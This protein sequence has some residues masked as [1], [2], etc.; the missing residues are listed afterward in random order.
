[1]KK[2]IAN[3]KAYQTFAAWISGERLPH[4]IL[5][6][7]PPGCGKSTFARQLAM[8]ALCEAPAAQKP[9]GICRHCVKMEK[10]IHPDFALYEGEGRTRSFHIETVR[11]LR[12]RAFIYPNE[13]KRKVFLLRNIQDMSVQAQNALLKI[14]EEPPDTMVFLC[15]CENKSALLE[16]ILSRVTTLA[17]QIPTPAQCA[18]LLPTL[19]PGHEEARYH[20]AAL[21]AAGNVGRALVL[22]QSDSTGRSG[23][24]KALWE[25]LSS[26]R[27]LDALAILAAYYKDRKSFSETLSAFRLVVEGFI[28]N[29]THTHTGRIS[30]LR[31]MQILA[32]I[33]ECMAVCAGN[34][35]CS[36]LGSVF[37]ARCMAIMKE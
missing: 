31:L 21:A 30:P 15:T 32:I 17:L 34:V 36:L 7:G 6:E 2:L 4:A 16:T 8:A 13:A 33:D 29:P 1:M 25:S 5:L 24:A 11:A 18:A 20:D 9:C 14:L 35:N 23:E 10:D 22:L 26:H 12:S 28:L 19:L 37:C 27:E 3:E